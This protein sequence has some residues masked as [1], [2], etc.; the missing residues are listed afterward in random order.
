MPLAKNLGR[1]GF[2]QRSKSEDLPNSTKVTMLSG[3]KPGTVS[4]SCIKK[5]PVLSAL[6]FHLFAPLALK[7]LRYAAY[8]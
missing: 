1:E 7:Q 2:E 5:R 3:E 8:G 6:I 4:R